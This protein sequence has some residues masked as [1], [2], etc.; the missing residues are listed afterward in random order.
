MTDKHPRVVTLCGSTRFP[1][2]F[3]LM[4]AHLTMQGDIVISCGLS[5][6]SDRP[7]GA[8]FLTSDGN[9]NFPAKM[10]LDQLH[11]R[12]IDLAD[13]IFVVNFAGYI[14][15]STKR[16]IW[17]AV[18]TGKPVFFM[19]APDEKTIAMIHSAGKSVDG[20]PSLAPPVAG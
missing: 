20:D 13:C 18:K 9:S 15:D 3:D 2:A 17:Y 11:L 5:G 6:H 10:A 1:E 4:N 7:T 19:F 12:K 16:E 14:G 8:K